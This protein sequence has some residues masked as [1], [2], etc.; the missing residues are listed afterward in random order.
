MSGVES[1]ISSTTLKNRANVT[2]YRKSV[3]Y[4]KSVI[5]FVTFNTISKCLH[6]HTCN[7]T[8]GCCIIVSIISFP[9]FLCIYT[10]VEGVVSYCGC[11]EKKDVYIAYKNISD[12]VKVGMLVTLHSVVL[13]V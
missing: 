13:I 9:Q 10:V 12:S 11:S 2:H 5:P 4:P 3:N 6:F 7:I 1:K 8:M